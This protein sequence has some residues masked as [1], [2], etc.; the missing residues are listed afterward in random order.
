MVCIL[1]STVTPNTQGVVLETGGFP[2]SCQTKS[3]F[4]CIFQYSLAT[5]TFIFGG[6]GGRF[7]FLLVNL[8]VDLSWLQCQFMYC[9][10]EFLILCLKQNK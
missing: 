10:H 1:D 5:F 6:R 9:S 2:S 8:Q 7:F 3:E 4:M